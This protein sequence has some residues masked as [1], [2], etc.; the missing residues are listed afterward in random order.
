MRGL[1]TMHACTENTKC[2]GFIDP[3]SKSSGNFG[4]MANITFYNWYLKADLE[5]AHFWCQFGLATL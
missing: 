3:Q 5:K 4:N 2:V 1:Q